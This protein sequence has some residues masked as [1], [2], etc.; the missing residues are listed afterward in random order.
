MVR[1]ADRHCDALGPGDVATLCIVVIIVTIIDRELTM[2]NLKDA[3]NDLSQK[4]AIVAYDHHRA[5]KGLNRL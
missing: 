3:V 5:V 2:T 4:V 1:A